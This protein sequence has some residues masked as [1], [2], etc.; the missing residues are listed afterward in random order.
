MTIFILNN[1]P[2]TIDGI[3]FHNNFCHNI[4]FK[5][6]L[7]PSMLNFIKDSLNTTVYD[8]WQQMRRLQRSSTW[9]SY[10]QLLSGSS[11]PPPPLSQRER[12]TLC[13]SIWSPS[14]LIQLYPIWQYR[15]ISHKTKIRTCNTQ[16]SFTL[17]VKLE[18][19]IIAAHC[20]SGCLRFTMSVLRHNMPIS[21]CGKALAG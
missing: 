18:R 16:S 13:F 8:T 7:Q 14:Q 11:A 12:F 4:V 2:F 3:N 9:N 1:N 17:P 6:I 19:W 10:G 20:S 15:N 21:S 5:I